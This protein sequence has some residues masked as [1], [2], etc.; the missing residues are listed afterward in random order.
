MGIPPCLYILFHRAP[1]VLWRG[2]ND[3]VSL[4]KNLN[5]FLSAVVIFHTLDE[6]AVFGV[7]H[8]TA[9][10][11]EVSFAHNSAVID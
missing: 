7:A 2:D 10:D 1:V 8:F 5:C 6:Q 4:F 11:V 3:C 9:G